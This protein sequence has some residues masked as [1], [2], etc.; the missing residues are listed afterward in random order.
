[1]TEYL[2]IGTSHW[3]QESSELEDTVVRAARHGVALIVEENTYDIASTSARRAAKRQGIAYLQVDPSP[4]EWAELG[5]EREMDLRDR[6]LQQEDVRLSHA[7]DLR[8]ELWLSR[9]DA[10]QF[11]GRVLVVCGYLHV[12]F[13]AKKVEERGGTV[14]EKSTFPADLLARKPTTVLSQAEL[15][16][17]VNTSHGTGA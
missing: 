13:L 15:E 16:D 14:A 11:L 4:A 1:M 9:I 12:D 8:E 10:A 6:C 7:D 17:Y 5:I 2:I 3:V